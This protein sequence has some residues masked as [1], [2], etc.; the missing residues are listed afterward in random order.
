MRTKLVESHPIFFPFFGFTFF[1]PHLITQKQQTANFSL[2]DAK[3]YTATL[4][5]DLAFPHSCSISLP[6]IPWPPPT[7]VE[8]S[9]KWGEL[10]CSWY[11]AQKQQG[12]SFPRWYLLRR[13]LKA[14]SRSHTNTPCFGCCCTEQETGLHLLTEDYH[15]THSFLKADW[16]STARQQAHCSLLLLRCVIRW[17]I[18]V[19]LIFQ[20]VT[21]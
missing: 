9:L 2:Q 1:S 20:A 11:R 6:P 19:L 5:Q 13:H 8:C 3:G 10:F 7:V 15:N 18:N 16:D 4:V 17:S 14:A 21:L 12:N